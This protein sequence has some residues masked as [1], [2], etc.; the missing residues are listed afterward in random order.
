M[1]VKG[2]TVFLSRFDVTPEVNQEETKHQSSN[3]TKDQEPEEV[4]I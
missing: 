1:I 3:L 4:T 2:L